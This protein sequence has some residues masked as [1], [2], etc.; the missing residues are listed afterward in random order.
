MID[1]NPN[2][3]LYDPSM[4]PNFVGGNVMFMN[5]PRGI[6]PMGLQQRPRSSPL[7]RIPSLHLPAIILLAFSW[8]LHSLST[9]MPYWATY[10]GISDSRAGWNLN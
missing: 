5:Q 1:I 10:S 2:Q 8:I 9:F 7:S 6:N 4:P 3:P